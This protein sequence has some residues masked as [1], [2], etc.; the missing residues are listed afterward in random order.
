MLLGTNLVLHNINPC[1]ESLYQCKEILELLTHSLLSI[2]ILFGFLIFE[3]A[4]GK[5][6]E[7]K[8]PYCGSLKWFLEKSE[9][10]SIPNNLKGHIRRHYICKVCGEKEKIYVAPLD[11]K[12][13]SFDS[14]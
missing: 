9:T 4:T 10:E 2:L 13:S 11:L 8:C 12:T 3:V 7:Q 6:S 14:Q 5:K 1:L